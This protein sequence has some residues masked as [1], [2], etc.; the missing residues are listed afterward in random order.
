MATITLVCAPR[1]KTV[2]K[3]PH[4]IIVKVNTQPGARPI[5]LHPI[6]FAPPSLLD[7]SM[8]YLP[9]MGTCW[10]IHTIHGLG[11][12]TIMDDTYI[13][14]MDQIPTILKVSLSPAW[15][16]CMYTINP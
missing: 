1:V 16:L 15:F 6:L 8:K 7:S 3:S 11:T 4:I 5:K 9:Y 10:P 12:W 2:W 14:L 13:I